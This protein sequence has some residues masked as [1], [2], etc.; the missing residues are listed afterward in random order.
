[1]IQE[2]KTCVHYERKC[3]LKCE[4]C[5]TFYPCRVCHDMRNY[6]EQHAHVKPTSESYGA[7]AALKSRFAG[8]REKVS[9]AEEKKKEEKPWKPHNFDPRQLKVIS[10]NNCSTVQPPT[11]SCKK[12]KITF[13]LY[14]CDICILYDNDTSKQQW[15]CHECGVCKVGGRHNYFHCET[16]K[17]C[18]HNSARR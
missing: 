6:N 16:C 10:C 13:G 12:C 7:A 15:H 2:I 3:R 18:F 1:M 11:Q 14:F 4:E 9:G 17:E 5:E 8:I